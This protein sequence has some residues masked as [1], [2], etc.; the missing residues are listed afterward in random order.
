MREP[1]EKL[2]GL[3]NSIFKYKLRNQIRI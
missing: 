2:K 1:C 3:R